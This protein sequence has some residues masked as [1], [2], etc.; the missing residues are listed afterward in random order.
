M[1]RLEMLPA[2]HGDCLWIEYGTGRK[3]SRILMDG[4]PGR[5]YPA[6]RER[7]LHLPATERRFELLVVSHIDADHIEGVIRLLQDAEAL[8]CTFDRIWF[9][10]A[11]QINLVP[12]AAGEPL[13][14]VQGELLS[15]LIQD[16]EKRTGTHVWNVGLPG[17]LAAID[18]REGALPAVILPGDCRLTLISPDHDRLLA[19]KTRWREELHDAGV[20][21]GDEASLRREL[22]LA[23][24]LRP[25]GDVLGGAREDEAGLSELPAPDGSDMLNLG[26]TLGG[27]EGEAGANAPFGG[28]GSLANGASIA[29]LLEFPATRPKTTVILGA[30]AWASVMEESLRT[31]AGGGNR[32]I[33]VTGFKL[34]HHGSVGNTTESLLQRIRCQDYL[35][36]SSGSI[37]RHPH[38]RTVELVLA[39]HA[40]RGKPRLHF[41]Y[42]TETT[43][44]WN[45]AAD[46]AARG[47]EAFHPKGISWSR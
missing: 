4:G 38:P 16:Y 5:T 15:L 23:R 36:S 18:R 32:R 39:Q 37:Y 30:D 3:T 43:S 14:A 8:D 12:D 46:Q 33:A 9:N 26:D 44:A 25:L 31:L 35:F 21:R 19:L 10:G 24:S 27:E 13:G 40:G 47:Y 17:E 41:N 1:F 29:L 20:V 6:L 7:I 22:E 28:D 34:A 2:A 45:D 11:A 42:L